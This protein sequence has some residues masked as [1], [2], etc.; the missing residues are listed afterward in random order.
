MTIP[1]INANSPNVKA[2][3]AAIK[4]FAT[5][6]YSTEE[7]VL[8]PAH[9]NDP[10]R[11]ALVVAPTVLDDPNFPYV[12]VVVQAT[13]DPQTAAEVA[14]TAIMSYNLQ[15]ARRANGQ[16]CSDEAPLYDVHRVNADR[17]RRA[18]ENANRGG[19]VE[20]HSTK[21]IDVEAQ[22]WKDNAKDV[23]L[24]DERKTPG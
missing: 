8:N 20:P 18:L 15:A 6:D 14:H 16:P 9:E 21:P 3:R 11:Y 4:M 17:T 1:S 24:I 19:K 10:M 5:A 7:R 23:G 2:A 13:D 22:R 12:E